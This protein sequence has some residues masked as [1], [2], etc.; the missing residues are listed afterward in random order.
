MA[1]GGTAGVRPAAQTSQPGVTAADVPRAAAGPGSVPRR[2]PPSRSGPASQVPAGAGPAGTDP[3]AGAPSIDV[4]R[5][6]LAIA[7]LSRRLRRHQLAGLTLT[8]VAALS[9]VDRSGPLRLSELAA[10]EG[11]AP[12]T[13]TRLVAALEDHGYVE[14][15]TVASDARAS[16]LAITPRGREV[17]DLIRQDSTTVLA[18]SLASLQPH[19]L[20]ALA[21]ALPAI[22]Q[23]ADGDTDDDRAR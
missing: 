2:P 21:A 1:H 8:Q 15:G 3:A 16:E 11:V 20:A 5:L 19:Q 18:S 9:T 17:L 14:R 22:E 4:A 7:R 13:L 6:R 12:S 23:L 10:I